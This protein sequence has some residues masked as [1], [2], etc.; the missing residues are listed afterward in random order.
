MD[1][2]LWRIVSARLKETKKLED[3]PLD[4][5]LNHSVVWLRASQGEGKSV[6]QGKPSAM[7]RKDST[8]VV[9]SAAPFGV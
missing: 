2:G 9:H 5:S 6:S 1:T 7:S 8:A 3:V 4:N